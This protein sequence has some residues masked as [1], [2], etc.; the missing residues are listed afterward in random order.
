MESGA[1][2]A[3]TLINFREYVLL[4]PP[5]LTVE[6]LG[7]NPALLW[8]L[9]GFDWQDDPQG[10][11][12]LQ[13]CLAEVS[14]TK[15]EHDSFAMHAP[16]ELMARLR[17]DSVC[18][19]AW[20]EATR[21]VA[22]LQ[23]VATALTYREQGLLASQADVPDAAGHGI[24]A[25][26]AAIE[27]GDVQ[28]AHAAAKQVALSHSPMD[29]IK[30]LA[31]DWS[32]RLA[33][34]AHAALFLS[35]LSHVVD[36]VPSLA[37]QALQALPLYAGELAR[38]PMHRVPVERLQAHVSTQPES[39]PQAVGALRLA[40]LALRPLPG[41]VSGSIQAIVQQAIDAGV[42]RDLMT[43]IPHAQ[44]LAASDS[45]WLD[46]MAAVC[47][48][49]LRSMLDDAPAKAKYGWTHA[50]TLPMAAWRLASLGAMGRHQA[51]A[52]ATLQV[53]AFR[54][55]IGSGPLPAQAMA[56]AL[57]GLDPVMDETFEG[58]FAQ[59]CT[60]PDA[61]LVK[62]VLACQD[63]GQ[64]SP[65]LEGLGCLAAKHLIAIW[66]QEQPDAGL[67]TSLSLR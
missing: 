54:A 11:H 44:A 50:L 46:C 56:P 39:A 25:M 17:I 53:A 15:L 5:E 57:S 27:A 67:L 38:A 52:M 66:V 24:Q 12:S 55:V 58:L 51:L 48:V 1:Q 34:G 36:A 10:L 65:S 18:Q 21:G 35:H 60:R 33:C 30:A 62:Y 29:V 61:H 7:Q 42:A 23:A 9:E 32:L 41:A 26:Q 45:L 13:A 20:S 64:M 43:L 63:L 40:L 3:P 22:R 2:N 49:P 4:L 37:V 31:P 16:L 8:A 6:R 59:A 28:G 47:E 14:K 19:T